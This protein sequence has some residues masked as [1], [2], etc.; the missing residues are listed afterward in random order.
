MYSYDL[1][2]LSKAAAIKVRK[3]FR[4]SGTG[5]EIERAGRGYTLRVTE[6]TGWK[7]ARRKKD[8]AK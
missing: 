7:K 2:C 4:E 5:V 3:A 6:Y 8:G 1:R